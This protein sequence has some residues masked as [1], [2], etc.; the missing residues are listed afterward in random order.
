MFNSTHTRMHQIS[1]PAI[2]LLFIAMLTAC[3]GGG[4][5]GGVSNT[6]VDGNW[7]GITAIE[8]DDI[9]SY[10]PKIAYGPGGVA[11]AVWRNN[12]DV[13]ANIFD[14]TTWGTAQ[15]IEGTALGVSDLELAVDIHGNA[16]AVWA[17]YNGS[18]NDIRAAYYNAQALT[19][20]WET[21]VAIDGA[22][23]ND[24]RYPKVAFDGFGNAIVVWL[25][26]DG[27][28]D[29]IYTNRFEPSGA[30]WGSPELLETAD[31]VAY[32]PDIA[33]DD[34]GDAIAVWTQDN[35]SMSGAYDAVYSAYYKKSDGSWVEQGEIGE[36]AGTGENASHVSI[37]QDGGGNAIAVW[38]QLAPG[39]ATTSV[40]AN[41]YTGG[42]GGSWANPAVEL[43]TS[44]NSAS[45]PQIAFDST[46]N[47]MAVWETTPRV[48]YTTYIY[49]SGWNAAG[50]VSQGLD[51]PGFP[52]LAVDPEGN[53]I[54]VWFED[55]MS[56]RSI[57]ANRFFSGAWG[58]QELL[59]LDDTFPISTPD[60]A[61]GSDGTA[62]AI[63]AQQD[64]MAAQNKIYVN[65]FE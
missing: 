22:N 43:E 49:N 51:N 23:I 29:S 19:P 10:N 54:V 35:L 33:V 8:T 48:R 6:L 57:W 31:G 34:G 9:A 25:Q 27:T 7:T 50:D 26:S 38:H 59:E 3:A 16:M 5:G 24:A 1:K 58:T 12:A 52:R 53:A 17:H 21:D 41:R 18:V 2:V 47:A 15:A 37:A 64:P 44:V 28:A 45:E 4:G 14:G 55:S 20:D 46:G 42:A 62:F 63:W 36:N 13:Y 56:V 39:L 30:G 32:A 61:I 40:W 60:I 65:R 11:F